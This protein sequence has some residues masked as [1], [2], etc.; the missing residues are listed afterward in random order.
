MEWI[1]TDFEEVGAA[2]LFHFSIRVAKFEGSGFGISH[3]C[4]SVF[5]RVSHD[6]RI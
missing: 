5:I 1:D 3:P 6:N 2:G 4:P